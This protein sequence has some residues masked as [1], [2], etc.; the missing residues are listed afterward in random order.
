M[1]RSDWIGFIIAAVIML[2]GIAGLVIAMLNGVH[3]GP[4]V[5]P[6]IDPS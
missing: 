4:V 3:L 5:V 6:T 2:L 1:R